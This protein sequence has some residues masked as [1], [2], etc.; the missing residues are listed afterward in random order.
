MKLK[1]KTLTFFIIIFTITS[2]SDPYS[3]KRI[4]DKD[5]RYEFY[6]T[7]KI[8]T[9]KLSKNYYWFKGGTIHHA[10]SGIAGEL[11]NDKFVKMYHTNQLAEQGC[12]RNGLKKGLW[13]T[14]HKNGNLET[15]QRWSGGVRSGTFQRFDTLGIL[16][17]K[18]IY[19]NDLKF[20]K[21]INFVKKDTISYNRSIAVNKNKENKDTETTKNPKYKNSKI[22]ETNS[23]KPNF[24]QRLFS[25]K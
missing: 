4:S 10:T 7:K 5:F 20:G 22:I 14:W 13:K 21:W 6:T 24:F 12:F 2:F 16:T 23:N 3:I 19:T 1:L 9:P 17:E 11:L 15:T 8:L 25:K 18:G